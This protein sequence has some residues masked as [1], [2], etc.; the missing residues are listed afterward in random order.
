[1]S[2]RL[3][4]HSLS[5]PFPGS[6][7]NPFG[8]DGAPGW[9]GVDEDR[10][11]NTDWIGNDPANGPDMDEVGTFIGPSEND[12]NGNPGIHTYSEDGFRAWEFS[13]DT[14]LPGNNN[15]QTGNGRYEFPPQYGRVPTFASRGLGTQVVES[16][17][18]ISEDPFRP[19]LRRLL[20]LEAGDTVP[21][22]GQLRL[23]LNRL[24][25]VERLPQQTANLL[26][27][28]LLFRTSGCTGNRR[29]H[30]NC[31]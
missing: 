17:T 13:A 29:T 21:E 18:S 22:F 10:D 12:I 9:A 15:V 5:V 23:D 24:L 25:D 28:T 6:L 20:Y 11:G 30:N 7:T 2:W 8:P 26:R 14:I 19:Q 31:D 3:K 4:N 16:D 27:G 1:M